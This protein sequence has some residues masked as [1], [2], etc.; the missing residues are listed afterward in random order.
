MKLFDLQNSS[1]LQELHRQMQNLGKRVAYSLATPVADGPTGSTTNCDLRLSVSIHS[2]NDYLFW[3]LVSFFLPIE[4]Q[5]FVREL[6]QEQYL[7]KISSWKQRE[8]L[9]LLT[10]HNKEYWI[11]VVL[12][13][14]HT[15]N[16]LFGWILEPRVLKIRIFYKERRDSRVFLKALSSRHRGYRDKGSLG[17]SAINFREIGSDVWINAAEEIIQRRIKQ[18]RDLTTFILENDLFD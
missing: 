14:F 9:G 13:R 2:Y 16:E 15:P 17:N 5:S 7:H 4:E 8:V 11:K 3:G 12:D 6:I 18:D 1:L 10:V